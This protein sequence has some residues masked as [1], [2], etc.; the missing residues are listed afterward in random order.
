MS[1]TKSNL[2]YVLTRLGE[3]AELRQRFAANAEAVMAQ[4]P[5]CEAERAALRA[6][7][8]AVRQ[9]MGLPAAPAPKIIAVPARAFAEAA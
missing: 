1:N 8:G 5:L 3:D 9:A 6:G 2:L 4:M 7:A